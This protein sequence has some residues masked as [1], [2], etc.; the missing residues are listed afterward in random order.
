LDSAI[1][2]YIIDE[3]LSGKESPTFTRE[4]EYIKNNVSQLNA[5]E[6]S[7]KKL[8]NRLNSPGYSLKINPEM[9]RYN[10]L[11]LW[12]SEAYMLTT[13]G[14]FITHPGDNKARTIFNY[15]YGNYGQQVKRNVSQTASKH[16]EVQ[17]SLKGIREKLRVLFIEDE[18]DSSFT[19]KGDYEKF[20]IKVHDGAT[21]YNGT[22]VELDNNSLGADA[23]GQD[24]KPFLHMIDPVTGC[25]II[26]KTA[27]FA[28]TNSHI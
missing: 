18:R 23:M 22:M 7:T 25:A 9:E 27:G 16:R 17:N 13:A 5:E 14:S 20:G 3:I 26:I 2:K 10:A 6:E 11:N 12:L 24:K 1:N 19:L 21:W 4:L 15:E 8:V 28:I